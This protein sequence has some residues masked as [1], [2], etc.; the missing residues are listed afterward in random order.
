MPANCDV[1]II[2]PIS[3]HFGTI[4][5]LDSRHI[6]QKCCFAKKNAGISKIKRALV[7]KGIFSETTCVCSLHVRTYQISCFQHNSNEF[8]TGSNFNCFSLQFQ[9]FLFLNQISDL[10]QTSV[11]CLRLIISVQIFINMIFNNTDGNH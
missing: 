11:L 6:C 1:I 9:C 2:F 4:W 7:L 5:K 10:S 8:Q 3:G